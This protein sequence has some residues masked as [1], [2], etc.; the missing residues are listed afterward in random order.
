MNEEFIYLNAIST[1]LRNFKKKKKNLWNM[2]CPFCGDSTYDRRKARGYI[3]SEKGKMF[4][5]CHNCHI[6]LNFSNFLKR[7]DDDVFQKYLLEKFR[8]AE[9]DKREREVAESKKHGTNIA[10]LLENKQTN[11]KQ[12]EQY[13]IGPIIE[14][15]ENNPAR[16]YCELRKIPQKHMKTLYFVKNYKKFANL[17][18]N[19]QVFVNE[20]EAGPRLVIPFFDENNEPMA[21]QGRALS[22]KENIKYL[23]FQINGSERKIFG[24]NLLDASK[25]VYVVEGPIDAMF[26]ENAIAVAGSDLNTSNICFDDQVFIFDNEPRNK[27][28]VKKMNELAE[29][30]EKLFV[31]PDFMRFKDINEWAMI[32]DPSNIQK[33][34]DNNT[35]S[36]LEAKLKITGWKK[37]NQ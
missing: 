27:Q 24:L 21:F 19:E 37:I 5:Y 23:T 13:L 30:G 4:Y 25:R 33:I 14:L 1:R 12:I 9:R 7:I 3:L 17:V 32:E 15:S 16:R 20:F 28:I 2:S 6:S 10:E 22:K 34:I 29:K 36:G 35:Y 31:P 18:S 11:W 26:L 8:N